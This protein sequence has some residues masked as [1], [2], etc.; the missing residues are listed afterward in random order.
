MTSVDSIVTATAGELKAISSSHQ[1]GSCYNLDLR[2]KQQ[3]ENPELF[4]EAWI[5]TFC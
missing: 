5:I 2:V 1:K 4:C 3:F